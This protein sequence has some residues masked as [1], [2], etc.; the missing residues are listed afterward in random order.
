MPGAHNLNPRFIN[1]FRVTFKVKSEWRIVDLQEPFGIL[2]I[3]RN[4][5]RSAQLSGVVV[6]LGRQLQRLAQGNALSCGSG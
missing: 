5:D 3:P 1:N 4:N 2:R 6:L